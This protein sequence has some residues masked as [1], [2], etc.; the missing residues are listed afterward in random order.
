MGGRRGSNTSE[1]FGGGKEE[2][3]SPSLPSALRG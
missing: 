1:R 3:V 2:S